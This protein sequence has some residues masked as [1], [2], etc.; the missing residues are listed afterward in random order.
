ME[1]FD[2]KFFDRIN[3]S[4]EGISTEDFLS[5][6]T[7]KAQQI[8]TVQSLTALLEEK[9]KLKVKFGIDPTG[10][11]VH[12]GHLVPVMILHQFL[13][14]G[15]SVDFVLG[16]F[17]ARIGDPAGRETSRAPLT[18]E[19]IEANQATYT[20]QISRFI[21][22]SKLS[23]RKNSE[24]LSS[25]TLEK[26]LP[27]LQSISM[28]EAVQRE[29]FRA[30]FKN[31]QAVSIAE[32]TYGVL[33]GLD[34]VALETDI[35]LG[36]IDQLL[37]FQQCRAVQTH[38]GQKEEVV[39]TTPILEGTS[40]DGRK[41]SKSFNNYIAATAPVSEKFGKIMSIP[42]NLI[43]SYFKSFADIRAQEIEEMTS[44]IAENPFEMKK[45]L[46]SF[47]VGLE[48]GSLENGY[49]ERENFE[50]KFS[51]VKITEKDVQKITVSA[52]VQLFDA[53]FSTGVF[54][55]KAELRRLFEQNAV[56][57]VNE[58]SVLSVDTP[59]DQIEG[60]LR[61]GKLRFFSIEIE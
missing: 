30:R 54:E 10:F 7:P 35:E 42:D 50:S 39:I 6:L 38:F 29:D 27:V 11:D 17:T 25:M 12:L 56:R 8:I 4:W 14:A 23:V 47:I 49:I 18:Q 2:Q 41:M 22:V 43:L 24:W 55:S 33:M 36:G 53:L 3:E 5:Y 34:S 31:D 19:Q 1:R 58:E 48:T 13:R 37:N 21:N 40:G 60:F 32:A 45:Q 52:G 16:D 59:V 44:A 46:A 57:Q 15:H 28:T 61:V 26:L 20:K 51:D 9:R